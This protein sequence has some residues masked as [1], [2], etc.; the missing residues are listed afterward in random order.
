MICGFVSWKVHVR[1]Q[2]GDER[3]NIRNCFLSKGYESKVKGTRYILC[4]WPDLVFFV[5]LHGFAV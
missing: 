3:D 4:T 1:Y 5:K 2:E